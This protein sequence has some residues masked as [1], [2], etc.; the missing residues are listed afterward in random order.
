VLPD[1]CFP[2]PLLSS[3]WWPLFG[4]AKPPGLD[5]SCGV[6][7]PGTCEAESYMEKLVFTRACLSDVRVIMAIYVCILGRVSMSDGDG[8]YSCT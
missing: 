1:R 4:G 8:M 2:I 5:I 3:G 6:D 7:R